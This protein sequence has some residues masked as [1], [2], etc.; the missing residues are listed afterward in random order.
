MELPRA[1]IRRNHVRFVFYLVSE[2]AQ[3]I[4]VREAHGL[5]L[6]VFEGHPD[7]GDLFLGDEGGLVDGLFRR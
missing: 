1:G 2:L 4:V 7:V 6:V 5:H 3:T